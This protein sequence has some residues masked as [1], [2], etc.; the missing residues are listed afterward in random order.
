MTEEDVALN[1]TLFLADIC[2]E[3]GRLKEEIA[4]E[5]KDWMERY[6]RK[7]RVRSVQFGLGVCSLCKGLSDEKVYLLF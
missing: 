3:A 1:A 6:L 4:E 7:K 2:D 5:A